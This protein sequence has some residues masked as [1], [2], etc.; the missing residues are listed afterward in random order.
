MVSLRA[1]ALAYVAVFFDMNAYIQ[2]G[3]LI[4]FQLCVLGLFIKGRRLRPVFHRRGMNIKT[5]I[6][7]FLLLVMKI[8]ILLTVMMKDSASDGFL[9]M[10][11]WLIILP[12]I[13]IQI[14]QTAY[15]L[16]MQIVNRKQIWIKIQL[17]WRAITGKKTKKRIKR[18]N[19]KPSRLREIKQKKPEKMKLKE[20]ATEQDESQQLN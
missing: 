15:P 2:V 20:L 8:V 10:L 3:T 5:F 11:G 13:V 4:V 14:L 16:A 9:I 18:V 6:E 7:E 17:F 1:V 12:A 19:V